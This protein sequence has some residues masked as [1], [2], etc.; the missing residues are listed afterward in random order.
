MKT[1]MHLPYFLAVVRRGSMEAAAKEL[2]VNRTTVA[3]HITAL[4]NELG[5][6]ALQRESDGYHPTEVGAE[7]LAI[8]QEVEDRVVTIERR[9]SGKDQSLRGEIRISAPQAMAA[10][11]LA[12]ILHDFS[13]EY[14]DIVLNVQGTNDL[15]NLNRGEGDV[16]LRV[17]QQPPLSWVGRKLAD[18]RWALYGADCEYSRADAATAEKPM[19]GPTPV[20]M[21]LDDDSISSTLSPYLAQPVVAARCDDAMT[22]REMVAGGLGIAR[23]PCAM[24]EPDPRLVRLSPVFEDDGWDL[25]ILT[26]EDTYSSNRVKVFMRFVGDRMRAL[27][28][29]YSGEDGAT[30]DAGPST[31]ESVTSSS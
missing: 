6:K 20:I 1:W 2:G 4:E 24:G 14:P 30:R 25:W 8:A 13:K 31:K 26:H 28:G 16:V 12:P 3:R 10:G 29:I 11:H 5:E 21:G 22:I 9:I 19:K 15:I 17:T 23:M 27:R 7:V 18:F